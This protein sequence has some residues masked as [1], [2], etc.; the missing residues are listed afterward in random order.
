MKE[1]EKKLQEFQTLIGKDDAKSERRKDQIVEWL[2]QN[3][4][5]D[6]REK[7]KA[8]V[9]QNLK[10]IDEDIATIRQQIA[11]QYDILPISYIAKHYFKKSA[12]WLHQRING[13]S[14]RGKVYTLNEEQ[15][16]TFNN[17]CKD[18]AKKIGSLQLT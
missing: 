15:K 10:R 12:S 4:D 16:Q 2:E 5:D 1:Y 9:L 13:Y 17:A 8:L 11:T 14:V 6:A 18:I 7:C 3:G